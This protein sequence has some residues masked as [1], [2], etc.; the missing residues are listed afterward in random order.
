MSKK[1]KLNVGVEM[2]DEQLMEMTGGKQFRNRSQKCG[3]RRPVITPKYGIVAPEYGV[4]P[5]YGVPPEDVLK[6]IEEPEE[7]I[8]LYGIMPDFD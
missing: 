3:F 1:K 8:P 5:M 4:A 6:P 7:M 2:T